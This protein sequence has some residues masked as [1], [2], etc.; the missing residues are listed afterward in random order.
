[1][2]YRHNQLQQQA[3]KPDTRQLHSQID[4]LPSNTGKTPLIKKITPY[5]S[6]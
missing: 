6:V 2:F 4:G 1:V 3:L 5:Q